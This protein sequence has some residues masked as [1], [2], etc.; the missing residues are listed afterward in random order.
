[1]VDPTQYSFRKDKLSKRSHPGTSQTHSDQSNAKPFALSDG[2]FLFYEPNTPTTL[3]EILLLAAR[4]TTGTRLIYLDRQGFANAQSY[5][6][7]LQN[8]SKIL[9][10]LREAGLKPK[11][12][13]IL[14]L[15]ETSDLLTA[16]W[17]CILGGFIPV[18]LEIAT[19][20]PTLEKLRHLWNFLDKPLIIAKNNAQIQQ[21]LSH[22]RIFSLDLNYLATTD[23]HQPKPD[24]VAFFNLTSGSTG[25][26]KCIQLTHKNILSRAIGANIHNHHQSDDIILNWLPFDH[27]GS[28]SDWH[29]RPCILGCTS[30]YV[31]K[32]YI[33]KRPLNWL[34]LI[35][36]YKV[37]HSWSPNFFYALL[38]DQ[39]KN[40][41]RQH[42]W[43]LS[44][45]HCL[46]TAGENITQNVIQETLRQLSSYGL[47]QTTIKPAFG[48]AEVGSGITYY[49][50][51]TEPFKF[52][53]IDE[54]GTFAD[55][56][57][58][59]PGITLRVVDDN[60]TIV[61]EDE[62]GYLQVRGE[63]VTQSYYN[64]PEAN[65]AAFTED[66][67]LKT[68]DLGFLK[69]GHLMLTGRSSEIIIINGT[70]YYS[71]EIEAIVEQIE[72][73]TVSYTAACAVKKDNDETERLAIFFSTNLQNCQVVCQEIRRSLIAKMGINPDYLIPLSQTEIPKTAIGKIQRSKLAQQ[74]KAGLYNDIL[75]SLTLSFDPNQI[76]QQLQRIWQDVLRSVQDSPLQ[77]SDIGLHDNFFELGG[78]SFLLVQV[79]Q[80]LQEYTGQPLSITE[81]FRHPTIYTLKRHLC[82]GKNQHQPKTKK[83][84]IKGD[85][86]VIGLSCRFPGAKTIDEFWQN[87]T[88]NVESISLFHTEEILASGISPELVNHPN[89]IKAS[90]ILDDIETFDAEFFGF[91]AA[92]IELI[93]PQQRLLLECA[94]EALEDAACNPFTYTG[95][96]G[97]YAGA[98][99]NTYLLNNIYPN[100]HRLDP[101]DSLDVATLDSMG[102]FQMM[103]A[104]D[105]DYLTTRI[106]YKLNLTGPSINV[107]TACSSGLAAI[108]LAVMS[109]RQGECDMALAGGVSVQV[110][111]KIGYLY[112]EGMILS[113]D[114]HCRAFDESAS[115]TIFGSGCG[116]V[117]LKPLETALKDHDRIYAVI[118]GSALSNDGGTKVGYFAPNGDG[119][120]RNLE[121]ALNN[122]G[123]TAETI[124]YIEAHGTGTLL[125]DPI[126]IAGLS[127]AFR[128]YTQKK[129]F[130]AIGSVKTNIGHLQIASGIAGF[131][132][133]VLSLYHQKI[134][135]SLHFKKPNPQIDFEH[136]PF[137]VNTMLQDWTSTES[138]RRAGVNSLGIGGTNVHVILE[139]TPT[140]EDKP[141]ENSD[142]PFHLF[143]LSAK[144]NT[145]LNDLVK[146]YQQFLAKNPNISLADLCFTA[147]TG[148]AHYS[149]RIAIIAESVAQLQE[150]LSKKLTVIPNTTSPK[151]IAFLFTGQGSQYINMGRQ[152]YE[153]QPVFRETL[154]HCADILRPFLDKYLLDVLYPQDITPQNGHTLLINNTAYTQPVLF[155]LE[156]ALFKLWQS[157]GIEPT[158]VMGHSIGE[159]VAATV[160]GVFSLEDGLK[161]VST[162]SKLMQALPQNGEMVAVIADEF[163]VKEVIKKY[164]K[165]IA[166]AA[167]NNSQNTVI[168]GTRTA[169]QKIVKLLEGQGIKTQTLN[170]S[171]GFHSPLMK[172]MIA[173]FGR[174]AQEIS[175]NL[176]QIALISNVTGTIIR[177][178]IATPAY[179][180]RQIQE[181][182][183]FAD[184]FK[185]LLQE[186]YNIFIE[187]GSKPILLGMGQA[188]AQEINPNTAHDYLYN[189]SLSPKSSLQTGHDASLPIILN[190]VAQL[191][192]RGVAID[193][194]SFEK[195]LSRYK[196]SLPTYPFQRKRYW[197]EPPSSINVSPRQELNIHPLL[198]KRLPSALKEII[199]QSCLNLNTLEWIKDHQVYQVPILPAT[200]YIE[201]ALAAG[202]NVFKS[203]N[204]VLENITIQQPLIF[205]DNNSTTI[206]VILNK[207]SEQ[208]SFEIYS[209]INED[210]WKL[211]SFG[212]I[213]H[214]NY[215]INNNIPNFEI[216]QKLELISTESFYQQCQTQGLEYGETFRGIKQLWRKDGQAL[217]KIQ[218]LLDT[219]HYL[220]HPSL[221]D[222][223]FQ[224]VL[225]A[226]PT[227]ATT[228]TY[229][230]YRIESLCFYRLLSSNIWS[231]VQIRPI[232]EQ[233]QII[234][235]LQIFDETGLIA[236]IQGLTSKRAKPETLLGKT[237]TINHDWFYQIEWQPQP[238]IPVYQSKQNYGHWLIFADSTGIGQQL[239]NLL[240]SQ[241]QTCTLIFPSDLNLKQSEYD[242]QLLN[243]FSTITGVIHL[244][245][246]DIADTLE[247]GLEK[248]CQSTL[249][250]VQALI[251]QSEPTHLYLITRGT[252]TVANHNP[253]LNHIAASPLWGMGKVIA[254][255]HPELNCIRIDLDSNPK[256]DVIQDIYSEIMT[257]H[258][259]THHDASLGGIEDQ[260]A[261]REGLRY[262]P[263][264][265]RGT[266]PQKSSSSEEPLQLA[267][268]NRGTIDNL[269]WQPQK[270]NKPASQEVEIQVW[271]T[272]LNFRDL[273]NV[274]GLYPVEELGLECVGEITAIGE[275]VTDLKIGDTV[276]AIAPNSFSQY[277]TVN[278]N[279][280]AKKPKNL[281]Y[282]EAATIPGAFLTAYYTLIHLAQLKPGERILIHGAATGVGLAAVEIAQYK[283]AEI[284][285][286][287]SESKWDYLK[288]KGVKYV[289]NS[290]NLEFSDEIMR[291][292][293]GKGVDVVLNSLNGEFIPKSLSVLN[294]GGRFLEIGKQGIWQPEQVAQIR[295]DVLYTSCDLLKLAQ[296][297]PQ[298]IKDLLSQLLIL[299]EEQLKPLPF[300]IF[301]S[302]RVIDA[303]RKMSH[304]KHI[305]KI[306]IKSP[307]TS[308][309]R[310]NGTYLITGGLGDIGLK[311]AQWLIEKGASTLI[312]VGRNKPSTQAQETITQLTRHTTKVLVCQADVSNYHDISE[313]FQKAKT[314]PPLRGI[315][316]AAGVLD[317]GILENQTWERMN[318][319]YLPKIQG[320]WNLHK[321]SQNL[322][323]D[324]F[325]LFSSA[326]SLLG[327]GGQANYVGAN[328]FLDSLA[329]ARHKMG[330]PAMSINWGA[331]SEIGLAA[332]NHTASS[333]IPGMDAIAP[334]HGLNIL[335]QLLTESIAQIGVINLDWS[336]IPKSPF[337]SEIITETNN[338]IVSLYQ[339]VQKNDLMTHV[340]LQ[341]ATVLGLKSIEAI[342]P[343]QGFIELGLD[344]L[345][346]VEFRNRLSM[347]LN[348]TL[349]ST[350]A[351]DYPTVTDLVNYLMKTLYTN[352]NAPKQIVSASLPDLDTILEDLSDSEAEILLNEMLDNL[353]Y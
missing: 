65:E 27:I 274:L 294:S 71:H 166:F 49:I 272:G 236:D 265:V 7:L 116:F 252:Q 323:L 104:N 209:L 69:K 318:Q 141:L 160:A 124:S 241:H 177:D 248:S 350:L 127:Q 92:E 66:G 346:S 95:D 62:I 58:P 158:A 232:T 76:E 80:Q 168:S 313:I 263:R 87:L 245:S 121:S 167:F 149:D 130:C 303:F 301:S 218:L 284:F 118:K 217:G 152:L 299:F 12:Q 257:Q 4:I 194:I 110:P 297:N 219:H 97:I 212:N 165:E 276:I 162:R 82:Q 266:L 259:N 277:V 197:I 170:T 84:V 352:K 64:N 30:I 258:I 13:V 85:I 290:R 20:T 125:G 268:K 298:L 256:N 88:N 68:G 210:E 340:L 6:E 204:L 213:T 41:P 178:E 338:N 335:E 225:A 79:Q 296:Q 339:D 11:D 98:A 44:S 342:D 190:S 261:F 237:N 3:P 143:T 183:R 138:P 198:G 77:K 163:T 173:E 40:E 132:K 54:Q 52:Y 186:G 267:I 249:Y 89:Y 22:P 109:L 304:A 279:L 341:L 29:L 19:A 300:S 312:L 251:K 234:A 322:P 17:G 137:Y 214:T 70:N 319:V 139:E 123:I 244:W 255:E 200:A 333:S 94:Y 51:K 199:F 90:P 330:L 128:N 169:I 106:S 103:V 223:C 211:H 33:L 101:N 142:R 302:K 148:R 74:F 21:Y 119:Q 222:A 321:L 189:P 228:E 176:P 207:N 15:E 309:I 38:N 247:Q 311:V 201:I 16:F 57:T 295:S 324:F 181:P 50:H 243:S 26:P 351:F 25:I 327:S 75:H 269:T 86:A 192:L 43:D 34:D 134:P 285:A 270:R 246:L 120:A 328:S 193:W 96:I 14:Q 1:M 153:T 174:I 171:H 113:A 93:D 308:V 161:L 233:N 47:A 332:R 278:G 230:P 220:S 56:G 348:C 250:L 221:L 179:W 280:V 45:V 191:Y 122:A 129:G 133:T 215:T 164:E 329:S 288:S 344:S 108:H 24:D 2:G 271:A 325:I 37:T 203:T 136:S 289:M 187:C 172:P 310:S 253:N 23:Y 150:Q 99:M 316:H 115:G 349:P 334:E 184:G 146:Q 39:L 135:A 231:Y 102:G 31:Q 55:L 151:K 182:V 59:I 61:L 305:G 117:L 46:L 81:L 238:Q 196:L 242:Q 208:S 107:Q 287:A 224:V 320:A 8:A 216:L 180:C 63:A 105:K 78:T 159:Y 126:E 260:I 48:M 307:K 111:Q 53:P 254:L 91:S 353:N 314:L 28:I 83:E 35:D 227:F 32:E 262:V 293:Q 347:T 18:I 206:Q 5:A 315:I 336:K 9:T 144:T 154:N 114:G 188:I 157:W 275:S 273:L 42:R 226:F 145:A 281:S 235:D 264:L 205:A 10:G 239:A 317:D 331:W 156:Y 112:Q 337:L 286:T 292:T 240:E 291:I 36:K 345:T 185:V 343:Q 229:L 72:G 175:Y 73:V 140:I 326:A 306:L 282:P 60:N 147:N 155:A 131:I 100:R 67:W 195:P 202:Q 283:G